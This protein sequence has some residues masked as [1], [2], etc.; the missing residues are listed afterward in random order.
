MLCYAADV[1]NGGLRRPGS[2]ATLEDMKIGPLCALSAGAVILSMLPSYSGPCSQQIEQT[3][4]RIDA[5]L[6]S[7]ARAGATAKQ[8]VAATLSHQPTPRSI[9]KAEA[10]IGDISP[11]TQ[12]TLA[13][14]MDRA[15][16]ADAVG[17]RTACDRAL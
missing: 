11:E 4:D 3:Q 10:A 14:A 2:A 9:A 7:I 16:E 5:K 13:D 6:D 8:S 15:R 17:D 12:R 1:P